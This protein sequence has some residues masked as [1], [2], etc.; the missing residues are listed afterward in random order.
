MSRESR[1]IRRRVPGVAQ[2]GRDGEDVAARLGRGQGREQRRL[3]FD[4]VLE[5]GLG[6][7]SC[8]L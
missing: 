4:L 2:E 7:E 3:G 8:D 5:L 6:L 1:C